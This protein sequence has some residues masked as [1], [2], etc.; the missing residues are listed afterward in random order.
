MIK[1]Q[2]ILLHTTTIF[3]NYKLFIMKKLFYCSVIMMGSL[4]LT[5]FF[6]SCQK[7]A[8]PADEAVSALKAERNPVTRAYKDSF[9]TWYMFVPDVKNGW[10]PPNP[11]PA[12]YPGGGEGNATHLGKCSTYYNQYATL[13]QNGLVSGFAPVNMFFSV[14]LAGYMLPATVGTIV[15]RGADAIWLGGST[16]SSTSFISAQRVNFHG[17]LDIIGGNGKFT[18]ATGH[19]ILNG[20][21]NPQDQ[22]DAS[23]WTEGWISY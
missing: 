19:V 8:L 4:V 10:T 14:P 9:D 13:G 17:E 15:Y 23:F 5:L 12:W 18:G 7:V 21:F 2:I 22:Q 11:G 1:N 20:Y 3:L 6:Y 16:N